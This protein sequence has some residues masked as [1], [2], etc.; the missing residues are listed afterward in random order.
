MAVFEA[1]LGQQL[2]AVNSARYFVHAWNELNAR[3]W[4]RHAKPSS[5]GGP[6]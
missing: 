3:N 4:D 6:G 5:V 2:Q 1:S